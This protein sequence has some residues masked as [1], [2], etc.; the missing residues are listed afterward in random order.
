MGG[1][2]GFIGDLLSATPTSA[3]VL[4]NPQGPSWAGPAPGA[5]ANHGHDWV[6]QFSSMQVSGSNAQMTSPAV[7]RLQNPLFSA[8]DVN[9]A[10]QLGFAAASY[11]SSFTGMQPGFYSHGASPMVA[12]SVYG[13]QQQAMPAQPEST[14][15]MEAFN[16]AFGEYDDAE[17]N[18]ELASWAAKDESETL[19]E[20]AAQNGAVEG[21]AS[22]LAVDQEV[23][24][25]PTTEQEETARRR[26]QDKELADAAN[27]I[28]LSVSEN[29]SEKFKKSNFFELMRRIGNHEVVATGENL[30]D[31][32]TGEA[33]VPKETQGSE[34]GTGVEIRP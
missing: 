7:P 12:P 32:A 13:S 8:G 30:V 31:A 5:L 18:Q 10:P 23:V 9:N 21:I 14:L 28:L 6:N 4:Q 22:D 15:D 24:N 34:E 27:H 16:A 26:Q 20:E 11:T 1:N 29:D 25:Q 2:A 17:F 3:P 19:A 33:V